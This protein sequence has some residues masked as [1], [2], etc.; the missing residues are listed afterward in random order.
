M[1]QK[2]RI[3]I[4]AIILG[5]VI[6]LIVGYFNLFWLKKQ[7]ANYYYEQ[8]IESLEEEGLKP[9]A[10]YLVKAINWD[11]ELNSQEF[12]DYKKYRDE[13]INR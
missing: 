5:L 11:P 3:I 7:V 8:A 12:K 1:N 10:E 6:L 13:F 2:K 9:S 4:E